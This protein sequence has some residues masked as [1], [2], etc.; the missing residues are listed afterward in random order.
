MMTRLILTICLMIGLMMPSAWAGE[1]IVPPFEVPQEFEAAW[2]HVQQGTDS[3]DSYTPPD[4]NNYS[5]LH[6]EPVTTYLKDMSPLTKLH[7]E[8]EDWVEGNT[9]YVRHTITNPTDELIEEDL[10]HLTINYKIFLN[11]E[12]TV[13]RTQYSD[14]IPTI[15]LPP[16]SSQ[17]F[18][19]TLTVNEPF[20]YIQ[21][22]ASDFYFTDGAELTHKLSHGDTPPDILITPIILPSGDIY[23]AM[24]NHHKSKT[25]TDIRN[26][27]L[28]VDDGM[29][30]PARFRTHYNT[31]LPLQLKPQ[32]TAFFRLPQSFPYQIKD[33]KYCRTTLAVTIDDIPHWFRIQFPYKQAPYG[34]VADR[35]TKPF[36]HFYTPA[37]YDKHGLN[38]Y[39]ASGTFEIDDTTLYGYLRIKNPHNETMCI[40]GILGHFVLF[41]CRPDNMQESV[42]FDTIFLTP[43]MIEPKK[44]AFLTFSVPLP[45]P[46]AVSKSPR[47][48][49]YITY[50]RKMPHHKGIIFIP[51]KLSPLEKSRYKSIMTV[52]SVTLF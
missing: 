43:L 47:L 17:S 1:K 6:E 51:K 4:R 44:E 25:I 30:N 23:L 52:E 40:P 34:Y 10:D 27:D 50:N 42:D 19:T 20:D 24:K 38:P 45:A 31:R 33:I 5:Y 26:I 22:L 35:Y 8:S 9:Y 41:Y 21:F 49:N 13:Y 11:Q 36:T 46:Q 14:I 2:Q 16:H 29:G 48:Q 12:K 37:V 3:R 28:T 32:E 39:E 7:I 15:S 18:I